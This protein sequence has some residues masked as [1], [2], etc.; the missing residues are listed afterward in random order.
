MNKLGEKIEIKSYKKISGKLII[1]YLHNNNKIGVLIEL[2][3]TKEKSIEETGKNIAMQIAAMNPIV[4]E[5]KKNKRK[6][7]KKRN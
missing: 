5:K 4:I 3:K 6:N 1:P 7:N 2:N